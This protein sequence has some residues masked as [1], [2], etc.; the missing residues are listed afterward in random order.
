VYEVSKWAPEAATADLG[1]AFKRFFCGQNE[2]PTFHKKGINDSF[3]ID[4]SV[5]K[6]QEK[7]LRLPK[8][9]KI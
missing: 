6:L 3:R 4:G 5:I 7:T 8:G 2:H 1:N 9:L